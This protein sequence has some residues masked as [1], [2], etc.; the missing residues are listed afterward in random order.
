MAESPV[1]AG[2]VH[3]TV[4]DA[5]PATDAE[6]SVGAPAGAYAPI[7]SHVT[8]VEAA[9][10]DELPLPFMATTLNVTGNNLERPLT[11]VVRTLPT[12]T[13]VTVLPFVDV[14]V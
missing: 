8:A 10:A 14:T 3:V 1:E 5:F 11:T 2:A 7:T 9:E 13:E 6:T 12:V 4:A